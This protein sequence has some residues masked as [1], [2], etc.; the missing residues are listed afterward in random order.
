VAFE[1]SDVRKSEKERYT[2]LLCLYSLLLSP[3]PIK[4]PILFLAQA[5]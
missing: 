2:S 1:D 5:K 3:F 4:I